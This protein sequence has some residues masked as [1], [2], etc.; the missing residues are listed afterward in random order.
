MIGSEISWAAKDAQDKVDSK[1][2]LVDL[3]VELN[4]VLGRVLLDGLRCDFE[5][6]CGL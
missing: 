5:L 6:N 2:F 4:L 3:Q 1:L